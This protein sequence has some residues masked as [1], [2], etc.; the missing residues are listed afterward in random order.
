MRLVQHPES[1]AAWPDPTPSD[2]WRILF[3][4]CLAGLQCGVNGTDYGL[5]EGLAEMIAL[6]TVHCVRFCPEDFGL[7]TPRSMPDLHGGDGFDALDGKA[8]V[9][10]EHGNDLTAQMI[11]GANEMLRVAQRERVRFAVLTDASAACGTQ[12]I[13]DGCRYDEPRR[14]R[15]GVGVAAATLVRAGVPVV[16][17][18]DHLTIGLIRQRL[19]AAY[20][21]DPRAVDHHHHP[22]VLEHLPLK[23]R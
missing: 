16:A 3:S 21:P 15:R 9:L 7:G 11:A 14:R 13:N 23:D 4:G 17:Q 18:R 8:R 10:D 6:P 12:V 20:Q 22:W 5:S 19:D 1:I 2:P